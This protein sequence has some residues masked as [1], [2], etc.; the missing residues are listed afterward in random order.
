ME[1]NNNNK[2][3]KVAV[4]G[5]IIL[6]ISTFALGYNYIHEKKIV[7][8]DYM[9][10]V[11]VSSDESNQEP[12]DTVSVEEVEEVVAD[13]SESIN[14]DSSIYYDYIG[15]LEIPKIGLKK[16]FVDKNSPYNDV[17][18][19]LFVA[20]ASTYPDVEGG[21]LIIAGHSGTG[22]KAFFRDLYQ[23][24]KND[25]AFVT[26]QNIRYHYKIVNIYQ[27]KK[28]GKIAV[29]R[30]YDKTTLTLVTCTKDDDEHQTVYILELVDKTT[31]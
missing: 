1:R 18:Q 25:E 29:Y 24:Q 13:E 31:I 23:L 16:G 21:N 8:F 22:Y 27:Q 9:T 4:I 5:T 28:T 6:M 7:A 3:A 14:T 2:N 19:N 15:Y 30:D 26:Y 17:E 20:L 12:I 10:D 11:L